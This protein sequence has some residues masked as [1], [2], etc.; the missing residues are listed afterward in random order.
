[1]F[2][3]DH[4]ITDLRIKERSIFKM[5]YSMNNPQI[6][7]PDMSTEEA[8]CYILFFSEGPNISALIGLYLPATDRKYVY[9]Y[10]ANPFPYEAVS[11]VE[12]EARNF[13]ETMGF[14]L[15]EINV[16]GMSPEDRIHW[17]EDQQIFGLR[18]PEP[19]A[20]AGEAAAAA[21]KSDPVPAPPRQQAAAPRRVAVPP[22]VEPA[23]RMPEPATPRIVPQPAPKPAVQQHTPPQGAKVRPQ[24]APRPEQPA[25]PGMEPLLAEAREDSSLTKPDEVIRHAVET[26]VMKAP[27]QQLKRVL[28]SATGLVGR[29]KEALARLLASF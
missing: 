14:L 24:P 17:F 18:K 13:A 26:G 11:D 22:P 28:R 9:S 23:A 12:E 3:I 16:G 5:L 7:T 4:K 19:A 21:P 20:P 1:M 8:R 25:S 10:N 29:D 6:A 2:T 15:D 27:K